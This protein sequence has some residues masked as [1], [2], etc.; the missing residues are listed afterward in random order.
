MKLNSIASILIIP[1]SEEFFFRNYI[2]KGLQE[3]YSPI[4]SI[5]ITSFLFG[6]IHLTDFIYNDGML[7]LNFYKTFAAF[8]LGI[9]TGLLFFKSKSVGPPILLHIV[10]NLTIYS[11]L[12]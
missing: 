7:E 10:W 11:T 4:L 5:F 8:F 2:Q 1:F 6:I 9:I 3:K 12:T